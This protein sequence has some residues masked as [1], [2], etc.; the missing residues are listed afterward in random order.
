M[1]APDGSRPL[2]HNHRMAV[3]K[4]GAG[5]A[6]AH[7]AVSRHIFLKQT[8]RYVNITAAR[9]KTALKRMN[10]PRLRLSLID[11]AA[12]LRA[13]GQIPAPFDHGAVPGR[14]DQRRGRL[15]ALPHER[16]QPMFS[17]CQHTAH[18][19]IAPVVQRRAPDGIGR[20]RAAARRLFHVT[21]EPPP[22]AGHGQRAGAVGL[23]PCEIQRRA[24]NHQLAAL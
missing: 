20:I 7:I 22:Q 9:R 16:G 8:S 11:E 19:S 12:A 13:A 5:Q 17:A 1:A 21:E 3:R 24:L 6:D 10:A 14:R 2:Q 15:R 4:R 18:R 23:Q